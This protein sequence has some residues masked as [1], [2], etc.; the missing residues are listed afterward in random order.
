[1]RKL[2]LT[3]AAGMAA[4][5]VL[6]LGS[7]PPPPFRLALD[8]VDPDLQRRTVAGAYHIHTHPLGRRRATAPS[9]P[10]RPRAPA[11]VRHLHRPRRRDRRP[12]PP[13]YIDGVLV[14]DGVEIS[15]DGG[16]YVA[17]DM[18]PAPY[19]LGGDAAA[20]V[21][22]VRAA[23]RVRHCGAPGSP[24]SPGSPGPTGARRSTA[25]SGSTPTAS[26]GTRGGWPCARAVFAY[27]LRP[28]AGAGVGARPPGSHAGR[29]GTPRTG[30]GPSS[31]WRRS[32]LTA[33]RG[34]D[35]QWRGSRVRRSALRYEASFRTISNRVILA[36]PLT[37][38]AGPDAGLSWTPFASGPRLL[39]GRR[40]LAGCGPVAG[41]E[42]IQAAVATAVRRPEP[43]PVSAGDARS[44]SRF[45]LRDAPGEPPVPWVLTNWCHGLRSRSTG[46]SS[47]PTTGDAFQGP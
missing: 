46:L 28:G 42:R 16:H 41:F 44:D 15:T 47:W 39:G 29:D 31:R 3:T 6:L 7:L 10:P 2:I 22:D 26:G 20:V 12:D 45:V 4:V 9:S 35:R 14:L 5:V 18:P 21:E 24:R 30:S 23:G 27:L 37:G 32:T 25:S 11:S 36:R 40:D 34:E 43:S 1:M 8:G 19:P 33:E 17:L 38:E 13:A